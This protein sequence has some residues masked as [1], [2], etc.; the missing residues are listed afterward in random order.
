MDSKEQGSCGVSALA[1]SAIEGTDTTVMPSQMDSQSLGKYVHG[2]MTGVLIRL[3]DLKPYVEELW[4]RKIRR[5]L[6]WLK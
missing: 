2:E 4:R 5:K 3:A 6:K 1:K